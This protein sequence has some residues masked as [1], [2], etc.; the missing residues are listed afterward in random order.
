[1]PVFV[2][3]RIRGRRKSKPKSR[4]NSY[5]RKYINSRN[6][7][8]KLIAV[9]DKNYENNAEFHRL[10]K[11]IEASLDKMEKYRDKYWNAKDARDAKNEEKYWKALKKKYG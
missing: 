10:Q 7:A 4:L 3:G 5:A 2:G 9:Q 6:N 11:K 8:K 1:M